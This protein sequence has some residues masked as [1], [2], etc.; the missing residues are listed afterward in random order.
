MH[1]HRPRS[2]TLIELIMVIIILSL[3]AAI[4]V[5][6]L[7]ARDI[8]A[9]QSAIRAVIGD[10]SFAASDAQ[11]NQEYRRIYFFQGRNGYILFRVTD[12]AF[13]TPMDIEACPGIPG[14]GCSIADPWPGDIILDTFKGNR[15]YVIEFDEISRL[16]GVTISDVQIDVMNGREITFDALGGTVYDNG[17]IAPGAGGFIELTFGDKVY[18]INIAPFTGKLTVQEL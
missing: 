13:A 12:A 18:R 5:P 8:L 2:Y 1:R 9:V 14:M 3:A 17:S 15:P 11:A 10:L 16:E 4:L 7:G 6:N